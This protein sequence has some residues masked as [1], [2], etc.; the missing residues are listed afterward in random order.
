[1]NNKLNY[2]GLDFFFRHCSRNCVGVFMASFY[3]FC[4]L[5]CCK[6]DQF[7]VLKPSFL[8]FLWGVFTQLAFNECLQEIQKKTYNIQNRKIWNH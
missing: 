6:T 2:S 7:S 1:M 8:S 3:V 5:S 4:V